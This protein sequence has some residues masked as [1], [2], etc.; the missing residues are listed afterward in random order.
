MPCHFPEIL[1]L[2][3]AIYVFFVNI[4]IFCAQMSFI[5]TKHNP[6]DFIMIP[7]FMLIAFESLK[8]TN[9]LMLVRKLLTKI[10]RK[11]RSS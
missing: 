10:L 4:V 2:F 8:Y 6:K 5:L 11:E 1:L 3:F 7:C 9:I